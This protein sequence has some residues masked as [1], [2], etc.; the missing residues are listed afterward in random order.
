MPS[1]TKRNKK[2]TPNKQTKNPNS[3]QKNPAVCTVPF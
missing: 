3:K 1:D 2:K